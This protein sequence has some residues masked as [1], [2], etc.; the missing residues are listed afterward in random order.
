MEH[1]FEDGGSDCNIVRSL[2]PLGNGPFLPISIQGIKATPKMAET[3]GTHSPTVSF[4]FL[5][6]KHGAGDGSRTHLLSLGSS[7]STDELRPHDFDLSYS[8]TK[9]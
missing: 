1:H 3:V 2:I 9:R 6:L 5:L 7:H 4:F 8:S